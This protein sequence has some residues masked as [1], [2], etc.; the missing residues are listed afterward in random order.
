MPA[1]KRNGFITTDRQPVKHQDLWK[2]ID[3]LTNDY[4]RRKE[5]VDGVPSPQPAVQFSHVKGHSDNRGNAMADMLAVQGAAMQRPRH[6]E[7]ATTG[8][9]RSRGRRLETPTS[10]Q[11]E[12]AARSVDDMM[13]VVCLDSPKTQL[14]LPC[15]HLLFCNTCAISFKEKEEK[16][17]YLCPTCR[18]KIDVMIEIF[19]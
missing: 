4:C 8:P 3:G 15:R 1:W 5:E 9:P 2:S 10:V 6:A 13:C 14:V 16:Q 18:C 19:T 7:S 11:S 12:P 17:A